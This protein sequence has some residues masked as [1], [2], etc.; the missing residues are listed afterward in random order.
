MSVSSVSVDKISFGY[1]P[2]EKKFKAFLRSLFRMES[3]LHSAPILSDI[4]FNVSA[5]ESIGIVG[6]NGAGKSTLLS[7]LAGVNSP[8]SGEVKILQHGPVVALLELGAGFDVNLSGYDNALLA[9]AVLGLNIDN[10]VLVQHCIEFSELGEYFYKPLYTY[11]SG[12]YSRLAF[13][14]A[15]SIVPSLLIIDEAL[16]V[17]DLGFQ[18]KCF[19]RIVHM[20]ESGMSLLLV[21]H[22]MNAVRKFCDRALWLQNGKIRAIGESEKVTRAFIEHINGAEST[23]N[24]APLDNGVRTDSRTINFSD[25]EVYSRWGERVGSLIAYSFFDEENC[26]VEM[27][28]ALKEYTLLIDYD[29]GEDLCSKYDGCICLSI[30][31]KDKTGTDQLVIST[32]DKDKNIKLE[33]SGRVKFSFINPFFH[34]ELFLVVALESR[35]GDKITY[36]DYI[37]GVAKFIGINEHNYYGMVHVPNSVELLT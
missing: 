11:S 32:G 19:E 21:S 25:I 8:S 31:F 34:S 36:F 17:G 35:L 6:K 30:S 33:R 14:V 15:T 37:D 28:S 13:S 22:D 10:E 12:M 5:G 1:L 2:K 18:R 27:I 29:L 4:S 16:S 9:K 3:K 26:Q 20:K 24:S 7:I 23:D